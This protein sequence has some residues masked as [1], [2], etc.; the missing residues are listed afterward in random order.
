MRRSWSN[1]VGVRMAR[2]TAPQTIASGRGV[3]FA[4][5]A[6]C[7][8]KPLNVVR[9]PRVPTVA[10]DLRRDGDFGLRESV[11]LIDAAIV[12]LEKNHAVVSYA[13]RVERTP[14]PQMN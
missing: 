14:P 12:R 8:S 2:E 9:S 1:R 6:G 13:L 11:N 5:T 4:R 7:R 3:Y 10:G